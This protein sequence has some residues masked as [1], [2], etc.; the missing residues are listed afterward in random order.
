MGL[1]NILSLSILIICTTGCLAPSEPSARR[2]AGAAGQQASSDANAVAG[3]QNSDDSG[4]NEIH[5]KAPAADAP[6]IETEEGYTILTEDGSVIRF[7]RSSFLGSEDAREDSA[8]EFAIAADKKWSVRDQGVTWGDESGEVKYRVASFDPSMDGHRLLYA[9]ANLVIIAGESYTV[10]DRSSGKMTRIPFP[11][12]M[13][14]SAAMAAGNL[15]NGT[16]FYLWAPGKIYVYSPDA[17]SSAD[18]WQE[19]EFNPELPGTD[20][21]RVLVVDVDQDKEGAITIGDFIA[22]SDGKIYSTTAAQA[23]SGSAKTDGNGDK[24]DMSGSSDNSDD[25]GGSGS[26]KSDSGSDDEKPD[27]D[28]KPDAVTYNLVIK[29]IIDENCVSCHPGN[30]GA[31]RNLQTYDKVRAG[32]M[33]SET[34]INLPDSSGQV[35]PPPAFTGQMTVTRAGLKEAFAKWKEGGYKEQ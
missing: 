4:L 35:M 8:T 10:L 24:G 16:G 2:T 25:D 28:P 5:D 7:S 15:Q 18:V 31:L 34:R 9:S 29:K 21:H 22:L 12:A 32:A 20:T 19:E 14:R 23:G 33:A 30:G 6:L 26:T 3:E 13:D 11:G 27:A 1:L 17:G